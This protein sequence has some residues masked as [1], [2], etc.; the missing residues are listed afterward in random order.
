MLCSHP[1]VSL[2]L[3]LP[4]KKEKEDTSTAWEAASLTPVQVERLWYVAS[5]SDGVRISVRVGLL[6]PE[7][8]PLP[9]INASETYGGEKPVFVSS[10]LS[11]TENH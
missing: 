6:S 5:V 1:P 7:L 10:S 4:F 11:Q 3:L 2:C 8:L 9:H